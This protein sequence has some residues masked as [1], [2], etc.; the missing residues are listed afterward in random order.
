MVATLAKRPASSSA[1]PA[2]CVTRGDQRKEYQRIWREQKKA[3]Q[4]STVKPYNLFVKSRAAS[5]GG[6]GNDYKAMSAAWKAL[7]AQERNVWSE[8]AE[9]ENSK[10]SQRV[11]AGLTESA[12]DT[13]ADPLPRLCAEDLEAVP[14]LATHTQAGDVVQAADFRADTSVA[15]LGRGTFG[16]VYKAVHQKSRQV[17]AMKIF[18][19]QTATDVI[20]RELEVYKLTQAFPD[21]G[22]LS[23]FPLLYHISAEGL[24]ALVV[25]TLSHDL[26]QN[27]LSDSADVDVA[28]FQVSRALSFFS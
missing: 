16:T 27:R 19:D 26:Y 20:E 14:P 21:I 4:T 6:G 10:I 3:P 12:E 28:I 5:Q 7:T 2:K 17:V 23:P 11:L 18:H 25:E 15:F 24:R 13:A 22:T 1:N 8:C 9:V